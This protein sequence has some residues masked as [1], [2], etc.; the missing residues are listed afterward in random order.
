MRMLCFI[1]L[2]LI[3]VHSA[4]A[5]KSPFRIDDE[6]MILTLNRNWSEAE[7]KAV[8][9]QFD[10]QL[11]NTDSA[12]RFLSAGRLAM[13]GWVVRKKGRNKVEVMKNISKKQSLDMLSVPI[14]SSDSMNMNSAAG[15]Q[16]VYTNKI[17]GYNRF[18]ERS[19]MELENGLTEFRIETKSKVK[20]VFLSGT[21]NT[22]ST[23]G[24]PMVRTGDTWIALVRLNPGRHEYKY[25]VDGE[26][27]SD[28]RNQNRLDDGYSD[29]NS[30]Y[31]KSNKTFRLQG[32]E[33]AKRVVLAGS[34]NNWDEQTQELRLTTAGWVTDMFLPDGTYFYKFIVDGERITDPGNTEIRMD[35]SG[36]ANSFISIGKPIRFELR[37][38]DKASK[39]VLAGSFNGW[40]EGS[41]LMQQMPDKT[42]VA[43]FVIGEGMYTY[44]YI[45]DGN[46]TCDPTQPMVPNENAG[47][48][49]NLLVINPNFIF[50][51]DNYDKANSVYVTGS[52]NE[53]SEPGFP[54]VKKD[55]RWELPVYLPSG[56]TLYKFVV[57]GNYIL[58]PANAL[59]EENE[60]GTGNSFV[61][62]E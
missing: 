34:F 16:N 47:D 62:V 23:S 48:K 54:L 44:K 33:K 30:V 51:L 25:I 9:V 56:K 52:F 42:W 46:W 26:W 8:L 18:E 31:F 21:F 39:V 37:N 29:Y 53:W 36:N 40:D 55:G 58:D 3:L 20:E 32:Y 15:Q 27:R 13:D 45:V 5:Q 4:A 19:V 1:W 10:M 61:W 7:M 22:W 11:L 28:P 60:F 6:K 59:Y 41:L 38:F 14:Y 17:V 35:V 2:C 50:S 57:D 12:F 49:N 24:L 43:E